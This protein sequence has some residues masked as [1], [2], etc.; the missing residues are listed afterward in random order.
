MGMAYLDPLLHD[1]PSLMGDQSLVNRRLVGNHLLVGVGFLLYALLAGI[2]FTLQLVD[3]YPFPTSEILSAGKEGLVFTNVLVYGALFN[4]YFAALYWAV[5]ALMKRRVLSSGLGMA[6]FALWNLAVVLTIGG[7]QLGHG[8]ALPW[9]ETPNGIASLARGEGHLFFA[10]ELIALAL[11]LA[12]VQF[13]VLLGSSGKARPMP[14]GGWFITGGLVWFLLAHV[15]GSYGYELVPGA[16]GMAFSGMFTSVVI[17]LVMASLGWG[18]L[19]YFVPA[20]SKTPVWSYPMSMLGFWGLAFFYPMSGAS[21]YLNSTLPAFI[22]NSAVVF[23]VAV[24]L[25]TLTLLLNF[26]MTLRGKSFFD[27]LSLRYFYTGMI[28]YAIAAVLSIFEVQFTMQRLIQFTEWMPSRTFL[29]LFGVFGFWLMG[30]LHDVY[31]RLLGRAWHSNEIGEWAYWLNVVG[32]GGYVG[33]GLI[34]GAA[35]GGLWQGNTNWVDIL[36]MLKGFWQLQIVM[37]VLLVWAASLMVY[38]VVMTR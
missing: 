27:N 33:A 11:L 8:Q 38:N 34:A 23:T 4:L 29:V 1:D 19:Y 25:A 2:L 6:I 13:L 18:I 14:V 28:F 15:I 9:G 36:L 20:I 37:L 7:I 5:P 26:F 21:H 31:P 16:G 10:D 24:Q 30:V 35:Q 3:N 32:V 17:G 22:Q 12:C